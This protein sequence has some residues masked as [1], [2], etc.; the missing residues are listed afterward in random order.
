MAKIIAVT[1]QKG[2]VGK[3]THAVNIGFALAEAGKSVLFG[4]LDGQGHSSIYISGDKT[5][6]SRKG[7]A[8][9]L[10]E[11]IPGLR[12][13]PT[14]HTGIDLLH[15]HLDLGRLDEGG[16]TTDDALALR[17]YVKSLPYDY[18]VLDT[19]P[20][21]QLR[22][23]AAMIWADVLV[24]VV[25]PEEKALRGF[26]K[27]KEV[28][29]LL[30]SK[31]LVSAD[32]KWRLLFNRVDNRI[33][34][35]AKVFE[36]FREKYKEQVIPVA[37]AERKAIV[38]KAYSARVPVWKWKDTPKDLGATWRSVPHLLGLL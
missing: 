12:G 17:E 29:D 30:K 2:G 31:S 25:E 33:A 3:T 1:N 38:N 32:Y 4:D 6:N 28:I 24:I 15:G 14:P 22:Q 16:K 26:M 13:M 5:I 36:G 35:Q 9:K 23:F 20:A 37:F 18:I 11:G 27:V 8:E 7:G 21:L 10:F 19:P 34:E